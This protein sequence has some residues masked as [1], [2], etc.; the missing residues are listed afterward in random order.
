MSSQKVLQDLQIFKLSSIPRYQQARLFDH[1]DKKLEVF[2]LQI[3]LES[4]M[5]EINVQCLSIGVVVENEFNL[6]LE[7]GLVSKTGR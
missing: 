4:F 3:T 6:S 2:F 1:F 7:I 5:I